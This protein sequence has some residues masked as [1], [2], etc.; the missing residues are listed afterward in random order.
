MTDQER[1]DRIDE[2]EVKSVNLVAGLDEDHDH[3]QPPV[4]DGEDENEQ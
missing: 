4:E 3:D 1:L 2:L